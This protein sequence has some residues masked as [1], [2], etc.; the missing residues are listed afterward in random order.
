MTAE[1]AAPPPRTAPRRRLLGPAVWLLL[2]FGL[3]CAIA[4]WWLGARSPRL[5][6]APSAPAAAPAAARPTPL[7]STA[8]LAP[9][10]PATAAEAFVPDPSGL[11]ARVARLE[12]AQATTARAAAA[13]LAA[14][15]LGEAAESPAG[16]TQALA[17]AEG[18]LP[19]SPDLVALRRLAPAGA[20]TRA[21]LAASYPAAAARAAAAARMP[22]DR[23]GLLGSL[24]R[25]FARLISV[26]RTGDVAGSGPDALLARA[27]TRL[28]A[29]DLDGALDQL[30]S[31]PQPARDA[32]A[33]W[34][35]RAER[36]AAIDRHVAAVRAQAMRDLA[37]VSRLESPG[38]AS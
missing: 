7:R 38:P 16:F 28:E 9:A 30:S 13:S 15:S 2:L 18:V 21:A 26:R 5:W 34:L 36:R 14:A 11:A 1:H 32:M 35:N 22:S 20:P 12:A 25:A 8:A 3:A 17:A 24:S 6:S 29:G 23:P 10:A 4:G 19:P 37:A 27:E 31:L 33:R